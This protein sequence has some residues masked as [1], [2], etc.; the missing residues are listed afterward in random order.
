MPH[1]GIIFAK[2]VAN[3]SLRRTCKNWNRDETR[4]SFVSFHASRWYWCVIRAW[5]VWREG[6]VRPWAAKEQRK[7]G[8][9]VAIMDYRCSEMLINLVLTLEFIT[10]NQATMNSAEITYE[11]QR[12][13]LLLIVPLRLHQPSDFATAFTFLFLKSTYKKNYTH[14]RIQ[15]YTIRIQSTSIYIFF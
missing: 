12:A 5:C 9:R 10:R 6:P 13:F 11:L 15:L 8:P 4:Q 1:R 2:T 3:W 7:R 14:T